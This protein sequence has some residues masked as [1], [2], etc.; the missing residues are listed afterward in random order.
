VLFTNLNSQNQDIRVF[1]KSN[2]ESVSHNAKYVRLSDS[3]KRDLINGIYSIAPPQWS[4]VT[5]DGATVYP[6]PWDH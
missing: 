2:F 3:A 4:S 5:L 6:A 1:T